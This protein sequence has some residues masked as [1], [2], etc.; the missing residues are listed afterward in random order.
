MTTTFYMPALEKSAL[1]DRLR[2]Y[3][4]AIKTDPMTNSVFRLAQDVFFDLSENRISPDDLSKLVADIEL[5]L[6]VERASYLR[7][8][9]RLDKPLSSQKDALNKLADMG[10]AAFEERVADP[11]GGIVFTA[12]PTF[13]NPRAVRHELAKC[14]STGQSPS[15]PVSGSIDD[16]RKITLEEEHEEAQ[17]AIAHAQKSMRKDSQSILDIARA[18][19]PDEWKRLKL[20]PPSI[21]SWVA[22][23][24]DGR[25]DISSWKSLSFRLNEKSVQLNRYADQLLMIT[26]SDKSDALIR[27]LREAAD[28]A[29]LQASAF[30]Q[31]LSVPEKL[32]LAANLLTED[33]SAR[34]VSLKPVCEQLTQM[35]LAADDIAA[36]DLIILR[37]EM[38]TL[39]L[40]TARIHLRINA[41]QLQS[42][43]RRDLGLATE[44]HEIGQVALDALAAKIRSNEKVEINFSDLFLEQ[45]TAKRQ[46]MMCAQI[47]KHIDADQPIRF[48]IAESENPATVLGAVYLA[49]FYDVAGQLDISPLFE[50]SE[51][52]ENGGRFIERLLQV[53]E[54]CDYVRERHQLSI[55]LGF[56]D[57][58][59]FIG[60]IAADIAIE[61][62]Q[63]QI[64]R[65]LAKH[66]PGTP[67]LFFDTHGESAGRGGYPGDFNQ[68]LRHVL[69][70]KTISSCRKLGIPLR[71]EVSFQGGDGYL[72]F[73]TQL[74]SDTAYGAFAEYAGFETPSDEA[75]PFYSRSSLVWDFYR[76]L[77]HWH[78]TL[79][80]DP[81]YA[82][83][84]SD[85]AGGF[86]IDAGSR[87][88]RR[89]GGSAGPR[90][91]RAI[92]HNAT[93]QQL[94]ILANTAA[95]IGSSLEK[96]TDDLVELINQSP[97]LR[98]LIDLAV[99][100][101]VRTSIP[102][103]RGYASVYSPTFWVA[104]SKNADPEK[105]Q[106]RITMAKLL[107]TGNTHYSIMTCA[108]KF[109]VD[110]GRFDR[111]IARLENAPSVETRH[112]ARLA[113]HA[114]HAIRQGVMMYAMEI[115]GSLPTISARHGFEVGDVQQ[116]VLSMRI[117]EA[118]DSLKTLFPVAGSDIAAFEDLIEP[119][120]GLDQF[121]ARDYGHLHGELIAPL[122]ASERLLHRSSQALS[123][124]HFAYG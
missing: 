51:A 40:G 67:L 87:P 43:I 11:R 46:L 24:L 64:A 8:Q 109:S 117:G 1:Y 44:N 102:S 52:L 73:N 99:F 53:P 113:I 16:V 12:H 112:E 49:R 57:A 107:E 66:L 83:L 23:D 10:F 28:L 25:N 85:F 55:Q 108:N 97:R 89:S 19:F 45:G 48:L 22:Y 32:V 6:F 78:E 59:R 91:L 38:E 95:G 47:L 76:A 21:S 119:R 42:V 123:H 81:N 18:R 35:A 60:Q 50:T 69:P 29:A 70:H 92:S 27:T 104:C 114:I 116:M 61:R 98:A 90:S 4:S 122:N 15:V 79:F 56:S 58:G 54:F 88:R 96:E 118:V 26:G 62:I 110:L 34:L 101:R 13:A 14:A 84:L 82:S 120:S 33:N 9:H 94:G 106:P 2:D 75:D 80:D 72:H 31:D 121:S 103:L 105:I 68:R 7:R 77:R 63:N 17:S 71:H 111:L 3:A 124:A 65:A 20:C 30:E 5:D 36:R 115:A 74:L 39:G 37:T 41:A 86:L 93:L 100:S